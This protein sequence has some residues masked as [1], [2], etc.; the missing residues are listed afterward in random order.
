[1]FFYC[2]FYCLRCCSKLAG[3]QGSP[4]APTVIL[5]KNN[6]IHAEIHINRAHVIGK[7]DKAGVADVV[8]ES[9]LSTIMDMEDSVAE[10]GRA[11]V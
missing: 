8:L 3:W 11:H 5:L 7:D 4:D 2:I 1:M 6:G 9:A 10:I